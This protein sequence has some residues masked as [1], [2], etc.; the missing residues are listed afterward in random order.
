[1]SATLAYRSTIEVVGSFLDRAPVDLWGMAER[2]GLMVRETKEW[3][4]D[5]SGSIQRAGDKFLIKVNANHAPTRRRFTLAHEIAHYVLHRDLI[6]NGITDNALYRSEQP[7]FIETQANT[8]AANILMPAKLMRSAWAE[9]LCS[10]E[11]IAGK[12]EVSLQA[13]AIRIETLNLA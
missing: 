6:G 7:G 5:I 4:N 11:A 8:Y 9:G 2:L 10:C 3:P 1:V 12:F 13:A